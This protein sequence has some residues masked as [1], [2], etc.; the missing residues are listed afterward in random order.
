MIE[1]N[2]THDTIRMTQKKNAGAANYI[3]HNT[4]YIM[5][6][7]YYIEHNTYYMRRN[8]VLHI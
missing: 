1:M 7:T 6:N 5:H 4:Y 2:N 8:V 3:E